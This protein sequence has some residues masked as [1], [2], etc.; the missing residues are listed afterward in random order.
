MHSVD[1]FIGSAEYRIA[2]GPLSHCP[3]DKDI[4]Q[5]IRAPSQS[6]GKCTQLRPGKTVGETSG[7]D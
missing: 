7:D 1:V 5:I 6:A 3:W 4:L 2:R